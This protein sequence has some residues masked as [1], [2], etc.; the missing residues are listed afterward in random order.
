MTARIGNHSLEERILRLL[1][2]G[3]GFTASELGGVLSRK[4]STINAVLRRLES[5]GRVTAT[6]TG[7]GKTWKIREERKAA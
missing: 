4:A 3:S 2:P 7:R 6:G 5:Q 1:K